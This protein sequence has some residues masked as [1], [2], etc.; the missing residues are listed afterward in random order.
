LIELLLVV[1]ILGV[2]LAVVVP[3]MGGLL[4]GGRASV[5][6]RTVAQAGR[7]A[8]TMALLNQLPM[9]LVLELGKPAVRVVAGAA[10]GG[11]AS[12]LVDVGAGQ[13][14]GAGF[15]QAMSRDD[16]LDAT[17]GFGF[18]GEAAAAKPTDG[19]PSASEGTGLSDE[20]ALSKDL[21][22]V[23]LAFGGY[24]DRTDL[25]GSDAA[26]EGVVSIRYRVNGTCRPYRVVVTATRTDD[27][28]VVD[29]DAVGTPRLS[30]DD[31]TGRGGVK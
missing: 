1:L 16:R 29:V 5:A 19:E 4:D 8:R 14:G 17:R 12:E 27:R 30:K 23:Q 15:G 20:L 28:F 3:R 13:G 7:Y 18:R 9:E 6:A 11:Y 2:S 24:V 22:G 31:G 10:S 21:E 26:A 25:P